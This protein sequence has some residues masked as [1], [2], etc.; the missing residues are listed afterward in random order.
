MSKIKEHAMTCNMGM[1]T[2]CLRGNGP[3][4]KAGYQFPPTVSLSITSHFQMITFV[5]LTE[6]MRAVMTMSMSVN[7][8]HCHANHRTLEITKVIFLAHAQ[9]K[10][11]EL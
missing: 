8:I 2:S 4:A 5:T 9:R 10:V 3:T 11:G 7:T 1:M 6:E